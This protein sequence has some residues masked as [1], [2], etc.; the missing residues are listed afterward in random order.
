MITDRIVRSATLE[1]MADE[2]G[3]I[4]VE[5]LSDLYNKI[6][7][8]TIITG[9]TYVSNN[10]RAMQKHQAGMLTSEHMLVWTELIKKVKSRT[11]D[12]KLFAQLA[13]TGRQTTRKNAMGASNKQ[14]SYFKTKVQMLSELEI[15]EIINDFVKSAQIV[16]KVGFDGVQIHA[17]HGYLIHQ[18]LS[19]YTNIRK[20]KYKDGN[21]FLVEILKAVRLA[22][23]ERFPIWVKISWADEN[24]LTLEQTIETVKRIDNLVDNIE[25]S[26]GTMEYAL[27]IIRGGCPVDLV[28]EVNPLFNRYPKFIK[29]LAKKF[30]KSKY[31]KIFKPFTKNYNLEAALEIKKH[32][33]TP[34]TVVGGIR[35]LKDIEEILNLGI[36]YVGMCRPFVCEPDLVDKI[37]SGEWRKSACTNCNFCTIYCDSENSVKCYR[38]KESI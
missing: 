26:Y 14:C 17:A 24:G 7:A 3:V 18:F 6:S 38:K 37:N 20:D 13:H 36:D 1:N 29:L 34:I 9:F 30:L 5:Q 33:K 35:E 12:K 8:K 4:D 27:N 19:H 16:K 23:G 2:N 32:I 11:P 25:I 21:L 15:Q 31:L 10:G 28:F 22:C